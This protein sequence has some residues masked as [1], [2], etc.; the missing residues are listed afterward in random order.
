[1]AGWEYCKL[2]GSRIFFLGA[3]MFEDKRDLHLTERGAWDHLRDEGWELVY[4]VADP[5]SGELLHFFKRPRTG[6]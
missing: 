2:V 5:E 6:G 4:V 3:G 1:M